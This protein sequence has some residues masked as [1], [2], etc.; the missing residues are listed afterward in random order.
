[1]GG[2]TQDRVAAHW[3][4]GTSRAHR[5]RYQSQDATFDDYHPKRS[6]FIELSGIQTNKGQLNISFRG[7]CD[8][9]CSGRDHASGG[10]AHYCLECRSWAV[11]SEQARGR[12]GGSVVEGLPSAQG[13][14]PGS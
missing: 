4:L 7:C 14:I 5:A 6:N 8:G 3:M 2:E 1:M 10:W 13:M 9:N 11:D 12:L